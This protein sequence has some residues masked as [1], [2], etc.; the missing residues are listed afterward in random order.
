MGRRFEVDVHG[1]MTEDDLLDHVVAAERA[2][3]AKILPTL[4]YESLKTTCKDLG[5]LV[6]GKE[7]AAFV[8][9]LLAAVTPLGK[10]VPQPAPKPD[11][12]FTLE[13][14][15]EP[16]KPRL[17]WQGMDRK[18]AVISVPTQV[19]EIVRPGR[20]RDRG[21]SLLNTGTI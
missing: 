9:A 18:E 3:L 17:A 14:E 19:V 20:A 1:K 16:R 11:N 15:V 8:T 21:D 7:K 12:D 5:V 6:S 10:P 13:L 2:E 4:A